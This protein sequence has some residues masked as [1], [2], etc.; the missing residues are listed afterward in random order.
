MGDYYGIQG[1]SGGGGSTG[2]DQ[3]TIWRDQVGASYTTG[4]LVFDLSATY[5]SLNSVFLTISNL[6]TMAAVRPEYALNSPS[7]GKVTVKLLKKR[8]V[9]VSSIDAGVTGQPAGVTVRTSSGGTAASES[10]HTHT[11]DHDHPSTNTNGITNGAGGSVNSPLGAAIEGHTHALDLPNYTGNSGAG[12]SHN[13]TDNTLY[14]HNHTLNQ[15]ATNFS[16]TEIANG[17]DLTAVRFNLL[18]F[19]V[20]L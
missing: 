3:Q 11:I 9:R 10:S 8:Y 2:S 15:S 12:T 17:T 16:L 5:S 13:H 19:G 7:A 14:A 4:G 1:G 20:S 18:A 6:S